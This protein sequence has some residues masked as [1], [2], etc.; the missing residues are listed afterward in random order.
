MGELKVKDKD[1]VVPGEELAVGMD[2]LP[3]QGT[4]RKDDKIVANKMGLVHVE[5][6]AIKLIPLAG[7]Y[8]PKRGD[9]I[10]GK[11]I[12]ITMG[13]WRVETNSAYSAMVSMK[14][15]TSEFIAKGANLTKFYT[16]GDYIMAKITNVTTQMLV[17]LTLRGPGLR[18]L[19]PGRIIHVSPYKVPRI[20]GKQGSMVSLIKN[21]TGC[22]ILVGQNGVVWVQGE[23]EGE[24]VAVDAIKK[25]EA[26][27]HKSG[28]TDSI[29]AFLKD[30][31][32]DPEF[33]PEVKEEVKQEKEEI[34][35]E[36]SE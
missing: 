24:I 15:A 2:Y 14:D 20:I 25:I 31:V 3:S 34:K 36:G 29:D 17:D 21:A 4:Y 33:K 12:D 22:K 18:K 35:K 30:K 1:I 8:L 9:V 16:F 10:I 28:L 6:R 32:K 5:G 13:G 11:V 23:P 26:E 19:S 7:R 27:S